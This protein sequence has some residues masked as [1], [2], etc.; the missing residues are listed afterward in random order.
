MALEY[1]TRASRLEVRQLRAR[2]LKRNMTDIPTSYVKLVTASVKKKTFT[3]LN[4][5]T[6]TFKCSHIKKIPPNYGH[7]TSEM[8]LR[9]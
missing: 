3:F 8:K 6:V 9:P 7:K 5:K 4:W 1:F 2:I